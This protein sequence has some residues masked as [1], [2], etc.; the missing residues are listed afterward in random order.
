MYRTDDPLNDFDRHEREQERMAAQFPKC[1]YCEKVIDD[2]YYYINGE[3]YC[4]GCLQE[5]FYHS[6]EL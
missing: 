6:I 3:V 5:N 2:H 4:E 1:D